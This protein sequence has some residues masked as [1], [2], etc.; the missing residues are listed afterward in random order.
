M[1]VANNNKKAGVAVRTD[2]ISSVLLQASDY[3]LHE[4]LAAHMTSYLQKERAL[5]F[6]CMDHIKTVASVIE[7][8]RKYHL[9]L[10]FT[11]VDYKGAFDSIDM[12][13]ILSVLV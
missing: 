12:N 11:F 4:I 10:V 3:S 1:R 9:P 5:S 13:A 7:V 6:S 8:C 2:Y